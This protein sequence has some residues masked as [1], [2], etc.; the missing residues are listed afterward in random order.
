M[1]ECR[2][3]ETPQFLQIVKSRVSFC[4][5][6][7]FAEAEETYKCTLCD[8]TGTYTYVASEPDDVEECKG[9]IELTDDRPRM[10]VVG[11]E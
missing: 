3:C 4:N 11:D 7:T 5:G 1:I 9:D 10:A 8:S 6:E 2:N